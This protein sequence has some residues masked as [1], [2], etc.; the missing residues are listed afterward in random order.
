MASASKKMGDEGPSS[1]PAPDS[2][3][4]EQW[5]IEQKSIA[6]RVVMEDD[7]GFD[8]DDVQFVSFIAWAFGVMSKKPSPNPRAQR[9]TPGSS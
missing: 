2:A 1:L 6:S 4:V 3:L 9:Y 5:K 8:L 7:P